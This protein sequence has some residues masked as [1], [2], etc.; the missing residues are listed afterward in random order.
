[1]KFSV[2]IL[3]LC[4]PRLGN[5]KYKSKTSYRARWLEQLDLHLFD[6]DQLLELVVCGKYNTYGKCTIDLRSL[7]RE[8]THGIWQ[9]L[10][11]CPGEV[12][13]MLTISGT[14]ASETIT[15]LTSYK[16]D[17]KERLAMQKRYVSS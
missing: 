13:I 1:M 14:T 16:E 6:D 15:D 17:S 7:P 3:K 9:P 12:H 2:Q 10:E 5:E 4:V 11:E 8:R